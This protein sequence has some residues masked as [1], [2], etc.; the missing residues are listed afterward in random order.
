[1]CDRGKYVR[2]SGFA[3]CSAVVLLLL[4]A[5]AEGQAP[6][7]APIGDAASLTCAEYN[8]LDLSSQ[9]RAA[10]SLKGARG[11]RVHS[12]QL[13]IPCAKPQNSGVTL[14]VIAAA[15]DSPPAAQSS[16]EPTEEPATTTGEFPE[17]RYLGTLTQNLPD[18]GVAY[19][20]KVYVGA[21]VLAANAPDEALACLGGSRNHGPIR[22]STVFVPARFEVSQT[23]GELS[24]YIAYT[25]N[26]FS[27]MNY[28][29]AMQIGGRPWECSVFGQTPAFSIEKGPAVTVNVWLV[30]QG[31]LTNKHPNLDNELTAEWVMTGG[32]VGGMAYDRG[33]DASWRMT[34]PAVRQCDDGLV[35]L[36]YSHGRCPSS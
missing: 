36:M 12:P 17:V 3:W 4:T 1:M 15:L 25:R 34:G 33:A 13:S 8:E 20:Q 23:K 31:A 14:G 26:K 16:T 21:P 19:Q 2:R 22:D 28:E 10:S 32:W 24:T 35:M 18:A 6:G 7:R 29:A 5:C 27:N 11:Y 9:D 30:G